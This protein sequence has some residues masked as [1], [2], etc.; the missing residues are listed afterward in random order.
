MDVLRALGHATVADAVLLDIIA[1]IAPKDLRMEQTLVYFTQ[2]PMASFL[3]IQPSPNATGMLEE[4][5][6][7]QN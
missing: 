1:E 3:A 5:G 4:E 2:R 7:C 6:K